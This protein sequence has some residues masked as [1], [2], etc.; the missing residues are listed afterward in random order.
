ML[1]TYREPELAAPAAVPQ[2]PKPAPKFYS[3][4]DGREIPTEADMKKPVTGIMIENSPEARPQSGLKDAE[5]VYEAVAEA[6]IT[7]FLALYQWNRP[8]LIGPV[9]SVRPYYVEWASAYDP[10]VYHVGGSKHA[11]DM[12]RSGNYG[13][14]MDQF[15]NPG[16]YWRSADRYAPHNVYTN[17]DKIDEL[18][19]AKGKTASTFTGLTHQDGKKADATNATSI[20]IDISKGQFHVEFEYDPGSN[21]YKRSQGGQPHIDREGGQITPS[22][23]IALKVQENTIMEDGWRENIITTGSGAAYVF[24]NGTVTECTWKRDGEKGPLQ[25]VSG[26]GKPVAINRGQTWITALEQSRG[27]SW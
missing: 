24:Q 23:V 22:V 16:T 27:V 21:T 11:L 20:N 25:L 6:G 14:D 4:L 10:A 7:R 1:G 19:S 2:K 13:V 26:D 3:P 15:F 12:I 5:L 18:K 9:R 8:G 17:F